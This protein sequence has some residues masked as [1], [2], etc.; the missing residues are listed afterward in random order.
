MLT[1]DKKINLKF[2]IFALEPGFYS[3][4]LKISL[5]EHWDILKQ[6]QKKTVGL[7]DE[8]NLEKLFA[9]GAKTIEKLCSVYTNAGFISGL[10]VDKFTIGLNGKEIIVNL[11]DLSSVFWP[12]GLQFTGH[13]YY[14]PGSEGTLDKDFV[15]HF[16]N[17]NSTFY[18]V[19]SDAIARRGS[20]NLVNT[21]SAI[22]CDFCIADEVTAKHVFEAFK[23]SAILSVSTETKFYV[24]CSLNLFNHNPE[25]DLSFGNILIEASVIGKDE[26]D[27]VLFEID[28]EAKKALAHKVETKN[29]VDQIDLLDFDVFKKFVTVL[30]DKNNVENAVN[31]FNEACNNYYDACDRLYNLDQR[32]FEQSIFSSYKGRFIFE[33]DFSS[34]FNEK[35]Y[36]Q[37][38][39]VIFAANQNFYT[40]VSLFFTLSKEKAY[41]GS[42]R[43]VNLKAYPIRLP[44]PSNETFGDF[45][46]FLRCLARSY[47]HRAALRRHN[48]G[49]SAVPFFEAWLEIE[50][51][52][53]LKKYWDLLQSMFKEN[54][55][56]SLDQDFRRDDIQGNFP[57]SGVPYSGDVFMYVP[58]HELFIFFKLASLFFGANTDKVTLV[59]EFFKYDAKSTWESLRSSVSDSDNM[60]VAES[61]STDTAEP[62]QEL[63]IQAAEE[64]K[65]RAKFL[66]SFQIPRKDVRKTLRP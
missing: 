46:V 47:V 59:S 22:E 54:F 64:I 18:A 35:E 20:L 34:A 43:R 28:P 24:F 45:V 57:L 21:V 58:K 8:N 31:A 25:L 40:F 53:G 26:Q 48:F 44:K 50:K 63:S 62:G 16:F 66:S 23:H 49:L 51:Q 56:L 36:D 32:G 55:Q 3:M 4:G 12:A 5:T 15:G 10:A 13:E 42:S 9:N 7:A 52:E 11:C 6:E 1:S 14:A 60:E 27:K 29:L 41:F 61:M 38:K 2:F 33:Y 39:T 37:A 17:F 19:P 65:N 30:D